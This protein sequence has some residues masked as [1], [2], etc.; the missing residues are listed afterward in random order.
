M[1]LD[2]SG[3]I[4][5]CFFF[6]T[7]NKW[8]YPL[9]SGVSDRSFSRNSHREKVWQLA[10]LKRNKFRGGKRSRWLFEASATDWWNF[11]CPAAPFKNRWRTRHWKSCVHVPSDM[12]KL[13]VVVKSN[14][15][16]YLFK[17]R[18]LYLWHSF[19]SLITCTRSINVSWKACLLCD[20]TGLT[21]VCVSYFTRHNL[22]WHLNAASLL[23]S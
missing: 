14:A 11:H 20:L 17:S 5:T 22:P 4:W 6:V 10:A 8:Y 2:A 1:N 9:H 7:W 19:M 21:N 16:T 12:L 18:F 15:N 13:P 3:G 23:F